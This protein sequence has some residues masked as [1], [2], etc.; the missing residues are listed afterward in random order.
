M[1]FP[2][3]R[4]LL[5]SASA[6]FGYLA[7]SGLSTLH[8]QET[9]AAA[10]PL[11]PKAPHFKAR[12]KRVIFLCMQGGPSHVD[13]FDYKPKLASDAGKGGKSGGG[14][15]LASPWKFKQQGKSGLWIS[16]LF[17]EIG[18]H[19]DE[20]CLIRSMHCDQPVHTRAMTQMH[21]G[22]AQFVRPSLGAWTLYGLGT[23]NESM[24][25]FIA[26]NPPV[27]S[28]QNFGS[29]FLPAVYAGTK[30]GRPQGRGMGALGNRNPAE[31][32]QQLPDIS[33]S[34][35]TKKEQKNQIAFLQD[36]NRQKLQRDVVQ[37]EVE[38][39]IESYELA[40]RMQDVVP[41]L[42]DI[43]GESDS[44]LAMYGINQ[45]DSSDFGKQCLMARRF[46]ESGVRFVEVTHGNWDHHQRLSTQLPQNCKEIDK[47][48]AGL[49]MDLKKRGL[50]K[51]TL[52]VWGGEFGRTPDGQSGDGRDHNHKGYTTWMA[53]G[54]VRGGMSYGATDDHGYQAVEDKCH[55]HDWHATMLH[56]LGLDHE[57]LTY[58]YAGR[59]FR[60]T[61]VH[62]QVIEKI[63][64]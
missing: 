25:G 24:P 49:L 33:N 53:G 48:I 2:T 51:D 41:Q 40:F 20:L 55:I 60:L 11:A 27:A 14:K 31:A 38:G 5:Q 46:I 16:E 6:G 4:E 8:A 32:G 63:I 19:A 12:A 57:R 26:L 10:N 45:G 30:V 50:L 22:T 64:A 61:D 9:A 59:N 43:S 18:K 13:T 1:N 15:L 7:F 35:M 29:S 42:M 39:I 44:T 54:G 56:L 17:P 36:L 37:P 23:E 52:V 28:A 34:R 47:P 21:T 58:R 3:R 62:G